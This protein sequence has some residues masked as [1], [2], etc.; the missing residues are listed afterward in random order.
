VRTFGLI[1]ILVGI[2]VSNPAEHIRQVLKLL[3][4]AYHL[5]VG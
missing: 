1:L 4:M 5:L 2:V 3:D